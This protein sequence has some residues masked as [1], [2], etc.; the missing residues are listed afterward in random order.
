MCHNKIRLPTTSVLRK[1]Q[2]DDQKRASGGAARKEASEGRRRVHQE[3]PKG[4]I[5]VPIRFLRG[6]NSHTIAHKK[7]PKEE[8]GRRPEASF[9]RH[10]PQNSILRETQGAP[11]IS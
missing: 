6:K 5:Q 7:R 1:T 4:S 11:G 2:G 3:F 10:S 8:A 9:K